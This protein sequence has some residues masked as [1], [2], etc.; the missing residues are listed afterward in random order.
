LANFVL[1]QVQGF[2]YAI[3]TAAWCVGPFVYW[4]MFEKYVDDDAYEYDDYTDDDDA[5]DADDDG[6]TTHPHNIPSSLMWWVT[7]AILSVSAAVM[8]FVVKDSTATK[9]THNAPSAASASGAA[10][11]YSSSS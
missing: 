6:S 9:L 11:A 7:A 8:L 10:Y 2:N 4:A 1:P 3:M 5:D